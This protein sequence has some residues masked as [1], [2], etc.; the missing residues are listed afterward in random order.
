MKILAIET[1]TPIA[2]VAIK[3]GDHILE[4]RLQDPAARAEGVLD[5]LRD[6]LAEAGVGLDAMEAIAFG[7]GPGSFTGLRV[8]AAV[9]QGLAYAKGLAVIPVSSLAALAQE[10]TGIEILAA[11][12]ARRDEIYYGLFRRSKE[13]LVE[14]V[15]PE[16]LGP[17][18]SIQR[19]EGAYVGVG[20]GFDHY[21]ELRGGSCGMSYEPHRVP[22]AR[23]VAVL[24]EAVYRRGGW[25][26]PM[27]ALPVYLRDDVAKAR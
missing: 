18:S 9:A 16:R 24:A 3:M 13:G 7:R 8:A 5:L 21:P 27:Q 1:A 19:P 15:G 6:L 4:R 11:M 22:S 20:S 17:P 12:D 25:V 10:A 14:A 26:T 23:S 2:S